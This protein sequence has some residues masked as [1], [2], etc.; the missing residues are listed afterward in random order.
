VL[1]GGNGLWRGVLS[2]VFLR[3]QKNAGVYDIKAMAGFSGGLVDL[4]TQ[5]LHIDPT[6]RPTAEEILGFSCV[7]ETVTILRRQISTRRQ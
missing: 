1:F 4:V 7:R 2:S 6:K 3:A 5:M